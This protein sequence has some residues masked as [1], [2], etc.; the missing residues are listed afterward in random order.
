LVKHA[1]LGNRAICNQRFLKPGI[2][3]FFSS[4]SRTHSAKPGI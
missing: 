1:A 2:G 3:I 4:A